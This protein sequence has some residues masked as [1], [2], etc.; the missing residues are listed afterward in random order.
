MDRIVYTEIEDL[1]L[2]VLIVTH[3]KKMQ[4]VVQFK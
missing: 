4:M 2:G 1:D 3:R